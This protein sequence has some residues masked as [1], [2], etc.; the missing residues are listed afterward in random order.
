VLSARLDED[1]AVRAALRRQDLLSRAAPDRAAG[2]ALERFEIELRL[3]RQRALEQR[4]DAL[5]VGDPLTDL[6]RAEPPGDLVRDQRIE[7]GVLRFLEPVVVKQALEQRIESS[8]GL[9]ALDV[10]LLRHPLDV[11]NDQRDTEL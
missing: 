8:L 10:V 1:G 6:G 5:V 9:D 3:A 2:H 4:Q 7:L 11:E